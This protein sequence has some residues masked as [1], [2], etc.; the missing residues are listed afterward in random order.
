MSEHLAVAVEKARLF[1]QSETRSQQLAVLNTIGAAVS[2]SLNLETVLKEAIEKMI[3]ALNFD[4]SWIYI[5]D[6]SEAKLRL[7]AYKGFSEE[8]AH[9]FD[10]RDLSA[11]GVSGKIFATGKQLVFE[12]L[13][14]DLAYRQ[15]NPGK[16]VASLGF[17]SLAGF[18]IR[19]KDKVIGVLHLAT[20]GKRHF[21][22][23]EL[24]LIESIAQEI[25]VAETDPRHDG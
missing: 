15:L 9:S 5:L 23:D 17:A 19:A 13:Q 16:K 25:G 2:Q 14:N 10:R 6:P 18:P 21:V 11:G 7:K 22:N 12:D 24:Q 3:E 4:A 20:K 8:I 1:R